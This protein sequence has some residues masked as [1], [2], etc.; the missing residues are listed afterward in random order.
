MWEKEYEEGM[1]WGVR[2]EGKWAV[3]EQVEIELRVN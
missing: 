2:I 3:V 1:V